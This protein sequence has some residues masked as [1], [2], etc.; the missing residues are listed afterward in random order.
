MPYHVDVVSCLFPHNIYFTVTKEA[1][2]NSQ[3]EWPF[4][5][6]FWMILNLAV[7]GAWGGDPTAGDYPYSM[8][9]DWVRVYQDA[10][11]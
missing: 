1:L 2:G 3:S 5:Q 6:P 8:S 11:L 10:N 9:V 7:G 4:D